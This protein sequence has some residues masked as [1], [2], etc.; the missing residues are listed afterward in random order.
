MLPEGY[1]FITSFAREFA[2]A[3]RMNAN[4]ATVKKM[5]ETSYNEWKDNWQYMMEFVFVLNKLCWE[6]YHKGRKAKSKL[7]SDLYYKYHYMCLD[8]LKDE[9]LRKY[10]DYLD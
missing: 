3:D 5:A 4:D 6:H 9:G 8:N 10:I 1:I 2:V 7:Y